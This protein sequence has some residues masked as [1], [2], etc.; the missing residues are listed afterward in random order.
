MTLRK[1]LVYH[2]GDDYVEG[3]EK[4]G[5]LGKTRRVAVQAL[6]LM[7]RGVKRSWKQPIDFFYSAG[8]TPA[9]VLEHLVKS[10]IK[11]LKDAGMG[12]AAIVSDMGKPN[13][14]LF[15]RLGVTAERLVFSVDGEEV[16]AM[17]DVPHLFKCVRNALYKYDITHSGNRASWQDIRRFYA[18]DTKRTV[19]TAPGLRK[20]HVQLAPFKKMKVKEAARS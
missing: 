13:Q 4:L 3:F 20:G 8:P 9:S 12:V 16:V 11:K 7:A 10:A 6:V 19:R 14:D 5:E 1:K 18:E 17:Y 15:K 2:R